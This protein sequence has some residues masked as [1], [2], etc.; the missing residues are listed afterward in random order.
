[1]AIA[2]SR[3][4]HEN[5]VGVTDFGKT[6]DGAF[7]LVMGRLEGESLAEYL[8]REGALS[9]ERVVSILLP[10]ARA[11]AAAHAEGIVHRDLK[12]EN[13]M[14]ARRKDG[15]ECVKVVDFG[16]SKVLA[17]P[18]SSITRRGEIIGTPDYMSPEQ[19]A[20]DVVDH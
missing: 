3:I 18:E 7:Y 4:G 15:S 6:P 8:K 2:A 20:A 11:L 1:E 14:L 16:I 19:A 10:I 13:V 5:I 9:P 17:A 12:A